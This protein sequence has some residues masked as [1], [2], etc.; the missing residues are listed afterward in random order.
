MLRI[1]VGSVAFRTKLPWQQDGLTGVAVDACRYPVVGLVNP[2]DA[3]GISGPPPRRLSRL[4]PRTSEMKDAYGSRSSTRPFDHTRSSGR[5]P[6]MPYRIGRLQRMCHSGRPSSC[7]EADLGK[8][9]PGS[10]PRAKPA[11]MRTRRSWRSCVS[12]CFR[13]W[14]LADAVCQRECRIGTPQ[15]KR[16]GSPL[17]RVG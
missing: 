16:I 13:A 5:H 2:P 12:A 8:T 7:L 17:G 14:F 15:S 4:R 1:A 6:N 9:D 10:L 11:T 3:R